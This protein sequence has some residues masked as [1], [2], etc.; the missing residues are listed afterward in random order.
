M[1][2]YTSFDT[3]PKT[4]G[5][6]PASDCGM[7]LPPSL[8]PE[9]VGMVRALA[10]K[11]H[12]RLPG[13]SGVE[14]TDLVQAGNI[15]LL[16]AVKAFESEIG[17]TLAGYA[18]FRVRGEMLDLVRRQ[19]GRESSGAIRPSPEGAGEIPASPD[20]SPQSPL[21]SRQRMEIIKEELDRLPERYRAVVR[22]R[23]SS[24]MTHREIGLALKV[25][26][27]RACQLHTKALVRLRKALH[28]RGLSRFSQL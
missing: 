7:A 6:V 3:V 12:A 2:E 16:K 25:K 20:S 26:E 17:A 4:S 18:K 9:L 8:A 28:G 11:L 14:M 22:L 23:Y 21:F 27:S 19:L 5:A 10:G 24:E 1:H 13:G 15:G